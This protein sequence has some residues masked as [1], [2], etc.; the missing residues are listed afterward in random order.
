MIEVGSEKHKEIQRNNPPN[1]FFWEALGER[2]YALLQV[3]DALEKLPSDGW[4]EGPYLLEICRKA[5]N[6]V[7]EP[8]AQRNEHQW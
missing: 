7:Y 6:F 8:P 2:N 5:V 1:E 4:S 3:I